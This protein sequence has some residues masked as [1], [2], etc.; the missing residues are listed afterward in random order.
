MIP[1]KGRCVRR[2]SSASKAIAS[3]P[4]RTA[5]RRTAARARARPTA[6][7]RRRRR[8]TAAMATTAIPAAT[9]GSRGAAANWARPPAVPTGPPWRRPSCCWAWPSFVVGWGRYCFSDRS[10]RSS[11]GSI[12]ADGDACRSRPRRSVR[13]GRGKRRL[14]NVV[15]KRLGARCALCHLLCRLDRDRFV[16]EWGGRGHRHGRTVAVTTSGAATLTASASSARNYGTQVPEA[17]M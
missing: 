9:P 17:L 4:A 3:F 2:D 14:N 12:S 15:P 5:G 7:H 8:G 1:A 16:A 13:I 11:V 6:T 10:S